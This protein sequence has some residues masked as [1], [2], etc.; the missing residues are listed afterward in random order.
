MMQNIVQVQSVQNVQKSDDAKVEAEEGQAVVSN[1]Q[2]TC[3]VGQ[4]EIFDNCV[5]EEEKNTAEEND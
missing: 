5:K 1:V 2:T 4:D 3:K